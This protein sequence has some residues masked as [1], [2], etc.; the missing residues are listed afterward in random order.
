MSLQGKIA[1]LFNQSKI[2]VDEKLLLELIDKHQCHRWFF[3]AQYQERKEYWNSTTASFFLASKLPSAA[4]ILETGCG[5]ALNLLWFYQHGFR[6]LYGVDIEE[7]AINVGK[8][9]MASMNVQ[10]TLWK[11]NFTS[12]SKPLPVE[13]VDGILALNWVYLDPNF[14]LESFLE[15]CHD[16]L[17]PE[18]YI[19]ID[20][21]DSS[22][23]T[24][25]NNQYLSSDWSKPEAERKPTEYK[26]RYSESEVQKIAEARSFSI[27][28]NQTKPATIPKRLYIFKKA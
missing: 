3:Y 16:K 23:N 22:Y 21:I 4:K 5:P 18:G 19:A 25:P 26:I 10:M 11:D 2:N 14:R 17:D 27:V 24:M 7:K 8:D 15:Y 28:L 12:P 6:N 1:S 9:L 13:K 20:L